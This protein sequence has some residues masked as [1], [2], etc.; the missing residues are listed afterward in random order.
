MHASLMSASCPVHAVCIR[1]APRTDLTT[2]RAAHSCFPGLRRLPSH[3]SQLST[4]P[5]HLQ[6][7]CQSR[8]PSLSL[9]QWHR[10]LLGSHPPRLLLL[11][12]PSRSVAWRRL[13]VC[14][15]RA[16]QYQRRA[17][18]LPKWAAW[19]RRNR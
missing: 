9:S 19:C 14:L 18:T 8:R 2:L 4:C 3:S 16:K 6:L 1:H 10:H 5:P 7:R 17:T 13:Q 11:L 12:L 15:L